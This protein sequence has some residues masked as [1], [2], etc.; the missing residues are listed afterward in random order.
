MSRCQDIILW[1]TKGCQDGLLNW[2]LLCLCHL[3]FSKTS[4]KLLFISLFSLSTQL[5]S[6]RNWRECDCCVILQLLTASLFFMAHYNQHY[7]Y[8]IQW[9]SFP[10]TL[11]SPVWTVSV[12]ALGPRLRIS[13]PKTDTYWESRGPG[14]RWGTGCEHWH[15]DTDTGG[16]NV[17]IRTLHRYCTL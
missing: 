8:L 12:A 11:Y 15:L 9:P 2:L 16:D 3:C 17:D 5:F 1:G 4:N 10:R 13:P 14:Q 6:T 7:D